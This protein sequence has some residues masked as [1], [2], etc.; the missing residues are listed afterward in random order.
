MSADKFATTHASRADNQRGSLLYN[1]AT[2]RQ[3]NYPDVKSVDISFP[4]VK[5]NSSEASP[6]INFTFVCPLKI[7]RKK[8][9]VC[10]DTGYIELVDC[11]GVEGVFN[12]QCPA[13]QQSCTALDLTSLT[14]A[15]QNL[16]ETA[17]SNQN[18]GSTGDSI[19]CRCGLSPSSVTGASS[20]AAGVVTS[21]VSADLSK[22]SGGILRVGG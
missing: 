18:S 3:D 15:L 19:T 7:V 22:A 10:N 21:P 11:K 13:L 1:L 12:G 14:V 17:S 6:A 5:D 4:S 20:I 16:C 9:Y 8:A 2:S